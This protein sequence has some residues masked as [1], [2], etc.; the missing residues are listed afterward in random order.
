M[1]DFKNF[2]SEHYSR[3]I[4][5]E[6]EGICTCR[7]KDA[8]AEELA[9]RCVLCHKTQDGEL[10]YYPRDMRE[11]ISE[12]ICPTQGDIAM[13]IPNRGY[14]TFDDIAREIIDLHR[15]KNADYGDA[16]YESYKEFGLESYLIRLTD[17]LN[18]AK[19]LYKKGFAEVK[20]E[21]IMDTLTDL[22]AYAI[23]AVE[24]LNKENED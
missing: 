19:M 13:S 2:K 4:P 21:S 20:S 1:C 22:A 3:E 18:R 10:E 7:G 5:I 16:A 11:L 24:A 8:I 17:K 14:K 15:K 12:E 9:K 6:E 23:M